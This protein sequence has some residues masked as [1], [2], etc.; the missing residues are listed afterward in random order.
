MRHDLPRR[1]LER[2]ESLGVDPE[3]ELHQRLVVDLDIRLTDRGD[4]GDAEHSG[5]A[6]AFQLGATPIVE[7]RDGNAE[8]DIEHGPF[9]IGAG[10]GILYFPSRV[11][12]SAGNDTS[13][14]LRDL[15]LSA[16]LRMAFKGIYAQGEFFRRQETDSLSSRPTIATGA[17][18]QAS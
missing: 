18:G 2:S 9:R 1:H 4:L 17:Y 13:A 5:G 16:S 8:N 11:F 3:P 14:R 6:Q 7:P 12:D 10:G 15:R